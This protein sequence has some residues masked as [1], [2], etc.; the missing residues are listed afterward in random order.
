[1]LRESSLQVP[2]PSTRSKAI[3]LSIEGFTTFAKFLLVENLD[4]QRGFESKY[5]S[6]HSILQ[7]TIYLAAH[8]FNQLVTLQ[9]GWRIPTYACQKEYR[10][11]DRDHMAR[12]H[13]FVYLQ[14]NT[15]LVQ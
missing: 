15:C 9:T 4:G 3:M 12:H 2:G 7:L 8:G 13:T 14:L 10:H 11:T 6:Y 1:M 5:T